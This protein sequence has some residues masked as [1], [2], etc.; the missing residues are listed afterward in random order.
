MAEYISGKKVPMW[1]LSD[2]DIVYLLCSIYLG[3]SGCVKG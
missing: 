1:G 2:K 3:V